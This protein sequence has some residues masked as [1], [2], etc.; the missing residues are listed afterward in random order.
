MHSIENDC[1]LLELS[2]RSL[3]ACKFWG[4]QT[5]LY[6][7]KLVFFLHVTLGLPARGGHSSNNYCVR[8][9][10]SIFMRFQALFR[11]GF[12]F[13]RHYT[14]LTFVARWRYN[15]REIAVKNC[16]KSKNRRK[17]LCAPLRID[18]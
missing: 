1:H 5:T 4:D 14:V 9:Y 13:Q 15:F 16:E 11:N 7:R 8:I 12:F 3:S 2:R 10:G 18:S 17:S 6:E